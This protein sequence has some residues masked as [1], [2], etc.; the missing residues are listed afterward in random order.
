MRLARDAI[1]DALKEL[2]YNRKLQVTLRSIITGTRFKCID[3]EYA[4][5]LTTKCQKCGQEDS[6]SHL[7]ICH[8]MGP[9][10]I[11][12]DGLVAYLSQLAR[13][14]VVTNPHLSVPIRPILSDDIEL[15]IESLWGEED[16]D[17]LSFDGTEEVEEM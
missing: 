14:A 7:L 9:V 6:P 11:D 1:R 12:H 13:K 8:D 15:E 10:P 4:G 3:S 17:K 5:L 16:M 2:C